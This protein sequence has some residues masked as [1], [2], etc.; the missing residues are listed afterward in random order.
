MPTPQPPLLACLWRYPATARHAKALCVVF[1]VSGAWIFLACFFLPWDG[2]EA[3]FSA[4][5]FGVPAFDALAFLGLIGF[6]R[7]A[8]ISLSPH[9]EPHAQALLG[10]GF[11]SKLEAVVNWFALPATLA[12]KHDMALL[13][14]LREKILSRAPPGSSLARQALALPLLFAV[15]ALGADLCFAMLRILNLFCACVILASNA[16]DAMLGR[17]AQAHPG[18]IHIPDAAVAATLGLWALAV[19][20]RVPWKSIGLKTAAPSSHAPQAAWAW[21]STAGPLISK[22]VS[23]IVLAPWR[24]AFWIASKARRLG[25]DA[26]ERV[27]AEGRANGV[28]ARAERAELDQTAAPAPESTSSKSR[29]L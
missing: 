6:A 22:S 5:F 20:A 17:A 21:A 2:R 29:R 25:A 26:R 13:E 27:L 28:Y 8:W 10:G 1:G 11:P 7:H 18:S 12:A 24:G 19:L 23:R 3:W 16:L 9:S 14:R 4:L 15:A